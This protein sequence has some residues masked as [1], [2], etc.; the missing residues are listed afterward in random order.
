MT[1]EEII[2]AL[3]NI[4]D[5]LYDM[6]GSASNFSN[7]NRCN[8]ARH[9]LEDVVKQMQ[10]PHLPSNLDEAAEKAGLEYAP[11]Q[12]GEAI[13]ANGN[14]Y[15]TDDVEWPSRCGFIQGFKAGAEWMARRK[16]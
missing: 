13:D 1:I 10:E 12:E 7:V 5:L 4:I 14:V 9:K 6:E 15:A 11:E 8:D 2:E 3:G 16:A